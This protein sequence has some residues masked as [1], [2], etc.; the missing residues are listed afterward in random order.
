[1]LARTGRA[2]AVLAA[3]CLGVG[4]LLSSL[5]FPAPLAAAA[6]GAALLTCAVH[7]VV[8]AKLAGRSGG[9]IRSGTRVWLPDALALLALALSGMLF[10]SARLDHVPPGDVALM[11]PGSRVALSG[12]AVEVRNGVN[13]RSR[14]IVAVD[15]ASIRGEMRDASGR[16][17]VNFSR[18]PA[19]E[20]GSSVRVSGTLR[21]P[22]GRRN[23]G[24]FN[25]AS[26]LRARGIHLT[27]S[28]TSPR[29]VR[30]PTASADL[31]RRFVE[32]TLSRRLDATAG[33]VV[34][35]LLLGTTDGM[36]EDRVEMFRRSGTVHILAVSGL[37]IGLVLL[38]VRTV[39]RTLRVGRRQ[40][41]V[42]AVLLLPL[43]VALV[44]PRPSA[45]RA[46]ATATAF[47]LATVL[48]RRTNAAN[49]LAVAAIVVLI[50]RPGD[51]WDLGFR[52]SFAAAGSITG[53]YG[54]VSSA[55]RRLVTRWP[56]FVRTAVDGLALSVSAQMGVAPVLIAEFGRLSVIAPI[57]NLAAV[58]LAS[59]SLACGAL[60]VV[61]ER[62]V[63]SLAPL[64]AGSAW[65]ASRSLLSVAGWAAA[66]PFAFWRPGA[67][68]APAAGLLCLGIAL[69]T[70]GGF[71]RRRVATYLL[72]AALTLGLLACGIGP[73]R[74][75]PRVTFYDVGQG[76]AALL[77]L[78]G[79]R[80][81]LVDSGPGGPGAGAGRSVI[82][83]HLARRGITRLDAL[84]V[85]HAHADHYGGAADVLRTVRVD[86]LLLAPGRK[87]SSELTRLTSLAD[88]LAVPVFEVGRYDTLLLGREDTMLTAL[89]PDAAASA[90][91][92]ENDASVVAS[93]R[94][95]GDRVLLTGDIERAAETAML[96]A[97][98]ARPFEILKVAHHGSSTSSSNE[99]LGRVSPAVAIVSVGRGN[100]FGHPAPATLERLRAAGI[101]VFRTDVDGAVIVD[102]LD[103]GFELRTVRTGVRLFDRRGASE[104]GE[105]DRR[106]GVRDQRPM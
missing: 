32:E 104:P 76:D 9:G 90:S 86:R 39:L 85:T 43:F 41:L 56:R 30:P 65:A 34:R 49:V 33:G 94:W 14:A 3:V 84:L 67:A 81:I 20:R 2:P 88:S 71:V 89:W 18:R 15:S 80:C 16:V 95:R 59:A 25:F 60:T 24:A 74:S 63:P 36:P 17:W 23:P 26:Y 37:H 62:A 101:E 29:D 51:L 91:L 13:G 35:G 100:R 19:V 102:V 61:A 103:E 93:L 79:G 55:L 21:R 40:A 96:A 5:G 92:S 12:S 82:C 1:M 48:E 98:A 10:A 45:V 50:L 28:S 69:R 46:S 105:T 87:A 52:L 4:V 11:S 83:P 77:E 7:E 54:V 31:A 97:G 47:A 70:P 6:C 64:F 66:A 75:A 106:R 42:V 73:V 58:P 72:G 99:F 44:G 38:M 68:L 53:T 57:A 78:V 8:T 22:P 27:L